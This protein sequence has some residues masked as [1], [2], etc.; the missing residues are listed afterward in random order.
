[1]KERLI[2]MTVKQYVEYNQKL[3]RM[4]RV[5]RARKLERENKELAKRNHQLERELLAA[6]KEKFE[7]A[8]RQTNKLL[9]SERKRRYEEKYQR[10]EK[11]FS[12]TYY[13]ALALAAGDPCVR[14]IYGSGCD[15]DQCYEYLEYNK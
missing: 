11:P 14:C 15:P 3:D 13:R 8:I 10:K 1:M 9:S 5:N 6:Q 12:D 2:I 7:S 4:E